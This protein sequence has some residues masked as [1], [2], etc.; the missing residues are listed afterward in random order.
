ME[1][2]KKN[3]NDLLDDLEEI[4]I[5]TPI[6][7]R[8]FGLGIDMKSEEITGRKNLYLK[9]SVVE[10]LEKR[11]LFSGVVRT[12]S[13]KIFRLK[14][15]L[16]PTFQSSMHKSKIL[17]EFTPSRL[18]GDYYFSMHHNNKRFPEVYWKAEKFRRP[19]IIRVLKY[20][21]DLIEEK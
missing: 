10:I 3:L 17:C 15:N 5:E 18:E 12:T 9:P 6:L 20:M 13:G 16:S 8:N 19:T 2:S 11:G 7:G 14:I 4:G 1:V 21:I